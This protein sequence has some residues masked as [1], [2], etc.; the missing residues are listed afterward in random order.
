MRYFQHDTTVCSPHK[1]D[2]TAASNGTEVHV[3]TTDS[4][5]QQSA[6]ESPTATAAHDDDDDDENAPL[7]ISWPKTYR[8][9]ISY[10][11]L[12]P[13]IF[14]LWITLPDTRRPV[15]DRTSLLSLIGIL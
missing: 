10:V 3:R 8:K 1:K 5:S 6:W 4:Q 12:A 15:S 9:R 11:L 2:T 14:P 13:I 7:D